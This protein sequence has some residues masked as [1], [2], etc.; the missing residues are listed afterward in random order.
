MA[1]GMVFPYLILD[2]FVDRRAQTLQQVL[3][4]WSI[5]LRNDGILAS[6]KEIQGFFACGSE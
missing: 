1:V 4:Y 2:A 5:G 6:C 3:S